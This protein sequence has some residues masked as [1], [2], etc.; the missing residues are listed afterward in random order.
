MGACDLGGDSHPPASGNTNP[1]SGATQ[2][3][4][5]AATNT[6]GNQQTGGTGNTGGNGSTGST[7]GATGGTSAGGSSSNPA[8]FNRIA[9][10]MPVGGADASQQPVVQMVQRVGPGVVTVVNSLNPSFT[11]GQ[12]AEARGSGA[13]IDQQGHIVTNNHVVE[14]Q[15]QLVVIFA[16]GK[17]QQAQLI[18]AD[19]DHDLAVLQISGPLPAVVPV[20]DSEKLLPGE[21]VIAIGS[22]LGEFRNTVTVGVVSGL[23]RSLP[24]GNGVTL[25]N[26]IQTDAAINHGNSGGPLLNLDGQLIGVN[27]LGVT[28]AGEG[29][30]AQGLGFAIP[31]STVKAV[32]QAIL[33]G[34]GAVASNRPYMGVTIVPVTPQ[35]ASYYNLTGPDGNPLSEG[36]LVQEV[37]AGSPAQQSGIQPGDV[38]AAVDNN[39][40]TQDNPLG[41]ILI[42]YKAGDQVTLTIIREGRQG[43]AKMTLGQRPNQ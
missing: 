35:I 43:T 32:T 13:I 16:D 4:F 40:V 3:Q 10:M 21:V 29:D 37:Q 42:N 7:G 36:A 6:T 24:E 19:P 38:I 28:Q 34:G 20:G 12:Q 5:P 11:G 22:A 25:Q 1:P 31:S 30:I 14:G 41:E 18:G 39:Q 27:T 15:Q 17:K 26:L 23:H 33:Q 2:P 9:A 8:A